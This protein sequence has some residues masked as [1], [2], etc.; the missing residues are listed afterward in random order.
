[1]RC[2]QPVNSDTIMKALMGLFVTL[3]AY[4][5]IMAVCILEKVGH[6]NKTPVAERYG[7]AA[8]LMFISLAFLGLTRYTYTTFKGISFFSCPSTAHQPVDNL[9]ETVHNPVV[10]NSR[11]SVHT[12]EMV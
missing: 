2:N 12:V 8:E 3:S 1:M 11:E 7:L 5:A 10:E 9:D 4:D 6:Y